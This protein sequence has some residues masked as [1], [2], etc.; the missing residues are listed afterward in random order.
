M[1]LR[2][3]LALALDNS[4][5][6]AVTRYDPYIADNN[7]MSARGA[8]DPSLTGFVQ[9][10][11]R[12]DPASD[13]IRSIRG[14]DVF[15]NESRV[16]SAA[17]NDPLKW[18][19]SVTVELNATRSTNNFRDPGTELDPRYDATVD[20]TY[21]QSLL[22]NFGYDV[23][24]TGIRVARRNQDISRSQFRQVV[25]NTIA[26]VEK[27]YWDLKFALEDLEVKRHS[28]LLSEE[29]LSQNK[30]RVD[31]G[32]LAPIDVTTAEAEAASRRQ[33]VLLAENA[34]E[35]SRDRLLLFLNQPKSSPMWVLPINPIDELPFDEGMRIDL[36][37]AIE[38]AFANRPDLE[39]TQKLIANDEDLVAQA[40][41]RMRWDLV[42]TA[43]YGRAGQ[44]G[45]RLSPDAGLSVADDGVFD[46]FQETYDENFRHWN[47]S[48]NLVV[49]L[50]NKQAKAGYLNSRLVQQ[51]RQEIFD[52]LELDA[53]IA[54][55]NAAR[56]V[57]NTVERVKAGRV[58][59]RLQRERL[60]AEN[61]RYENG[62]TTTFDL[63]Q[64]Q[65]DLTRA[66]SQVI[67]ALV[68]HNKALADLGAA[69]GTLAASRGVQVAEL[70][71]RGVKLP[72]LP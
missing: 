44:V 43:R 42:G 60:A 35:N 3:A 38:E 72:E 36:P 66:E 22:R 24:T 45:R 37:A 7:V 1:T 58:N 54:V 67:L 71:E 61:K 51:Q 40:R 8:F 17:Y 12:S 47:L 25:I 64:F 14:I 18:G 69:K 46:A 2:E 26:G 39:Q 11:D 9:V 63:F 27:A 56:Q 55:R 68:D 59:V 41:D 65:D 21:A 30:I 10:E 28:L 34:L 48:L 4:L 32:T 52:S 5:A 20:V 53:V 50:G 57:D 6:I 16:A 33:D 29:T 23:N 15:Q 31:V 62:M 49:P 70:V 19:G 13:F